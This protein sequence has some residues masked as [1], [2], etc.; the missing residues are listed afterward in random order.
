MTASNEPHLKR[1]LTLPTAVL[2]GLSYML[3]LTVFTTFGIVNVLTEGH[4]VS[5]Y[6]L[7]LLAMF[8]TA[9]SYAKMARAYPLAGSA[10]VYTRKAFGGSIGF[11]S[12][13]ALMLDYI[14][15]P[16]ITYLVIGIYINAALPMVPQSVGIVV[17]LLSVTALTI[18]G[19][20]SVSIVSSALVAFQVVFLVVFL[21]MA[22]FSIW[23]QP[24][25]DISDVM[26]G[27][28]PGMA[29]IFSGA[30]ILCFSFLGFDAVSTIAEE[31]RDAQRVIPRAIILV[32]L[33]GGALFILISLPA[34]LVMPDW[35][36][37]TDADSAALDVMQA[38]GGRFLGMFFTAAYVAGCFGAVTA[39]QT[40]VSRIL[41][42]MGRD[43]V[44][45]KS[46][47]GRIHPRFQT[48]VGAILVVGM[49]GFVALFVSLDLA[50]SLINFGALV[51]FT[52][53]NLSVI[54]H[55]Y[56]DRKERSG[57][58][59]VTGLAAP[60]IGVAMCVWLWLS[61]S[62]DALAIGLAWVLLGTLQLGLLTRWFTRKPPELSLD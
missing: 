22:G 13:W 8:F 51:A 52:S 30:A 61:L 29:T 56:I 31:T 28:G 45:P 46:V 26:F 36:A 40:T 33:I 62:A 1:T 20:R 35:T 34:V 27:S 48:P 43:G 17:S 38:A 57:W 18:I 47:F 25:P 2:F 32:T 49:V 54:K 60:T 12:G 44:I 9:A 4:I 39:S 42:A 14:L 58:S 11:L 10:Y 50:S 21:T 7:C 23:G 37:Y 24:L 59:L 55:F 6:M 16:M 3:P 41:Y 5:A 15:M 53:V 19:I